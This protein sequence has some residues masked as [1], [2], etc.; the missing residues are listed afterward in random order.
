MG[1]GHGLRCQ[2]L[3]G[4]WC[5]RSLGALAGCLEV[6]GMGWQGRVLEIG[7]RFPFYLPRS[8]F[9][10]HFLHWHMSERRVK[11]CDVEVKN[12]DMWHLSRVIR[13]WFHRRGLFCMCVNLIYIGTDLIKNIVHPSREATKVNNYAN[14]YGKGVTPIFKEQMECIILCAPRDQSHIR[15]QI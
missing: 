1:S 12:A 5:L 10:L 6:K 9:S 13:A 8:I 15:W 2:F 4:W 11:L 7:Q 14:Y 3:D